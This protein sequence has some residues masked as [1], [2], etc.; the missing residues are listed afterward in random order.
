M[1]MDCVTGAT[2]TL[3]ENSPFD[4]CIC[5]VAVGSEI[6][7]AGKIPSN[8]YSYDMNSGQ[9]CRASQ[10]PFYREEGAMTVSQD[11]SGHTQ[12]DME[13]TLEGKKAGYYYY[14]RTSMAAY[15]LPHGT[16]WFTSVGAMETA[17]N[18]KDAVSMVEMYDT[19]TN[20]WQQHAVWTDKNQFHHRCGTIVFEGYLYFTGGCSATE[21]WDV[22]PHAVTACYRVSLSDATPQPQPIA[23]LNVARYDHSIFIKDEHIWVYGGTTHVDGNKQESTLFECYDRNADRWM[24]MP[25]SMSQDLQAELIKENYQQKTFFLPLRA[26]VVSDG[27][28]CQRFYEGDEKKVFYRTSSDKI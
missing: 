15:P 23:H 18:I 28:V 11:L 6:Y 3:V 27:G 22:K 4:D 20:K 19:R 21:Y 1:A 8:W 5:V 12:V 26:P 9:I 7:G 10:L 16:I 24:A 13:R 2:R 17:E 14:N 25:V